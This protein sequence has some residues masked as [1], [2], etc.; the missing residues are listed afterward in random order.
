[1]IGPRRA[2]ALLALILPAGCLLACAPDPLPRVRLPIAVERPRPPADLTIDVVVFPD[3][4]GRLGEVPTRFLLEPDGQLRVST[5]FDVDQD[6]YPPRTRRLSEAQVLDLYAR[7]QRDG[8]AIEQALPPDA[9][10]EQDRPFRPVDLVPMHNTAIIVTVTAHGR[11]TIAEHHP[12]ASAAAVGLV[13]RLQGL[14]RIDTVAAE[15]AR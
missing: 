2:V 4:S 12:N 5:G 9:S 13:E 8:L 1:M 6:H 7:V 11:R 3:D 15:R 10:G 14:A